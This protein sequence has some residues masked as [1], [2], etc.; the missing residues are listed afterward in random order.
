M[1]IKADFLRQYD[2]AKLAGY[3]KS[4]NKLRK[5]GEGACFEA[6]L[7]PAN[8]GALP[9]VLHVAKPG[10]LRDMQGSIHE[11]LS[12]LHAAADLRAPLIPP[13]RGEYRDDQ[14]IYAMPYCEQGFMDQASLANEITQFRAALRSR[15]LL[16]GD[17]LQIRALSGV[18][19]Q[20]DW[21][22]L[23]WA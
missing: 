23:T 14:L 10:F 17:A 18:P 11:W 7:L 16:L 3:C 1:N 12:A 9:L 21:S 2:P 4:L 22:D 15:G 13:M 5:L 8:S 20:I 6:Y 19:Y